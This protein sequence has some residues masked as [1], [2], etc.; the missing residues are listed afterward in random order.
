M[1][2]AS[3][4]S[5]ASDSYLSH[6]SQDS[7]FSLSYQ[8]YLSNSMSVSVSVSISYSMLTSVSISYIYL[9][10]QDLEQQRTIIQDI[11]LHMPGNIQRTI[12]HSVTFT[13]TATPS[14]VTGEL[15]WGPWKNDGVTGDQ[16]IFPQFIS[17]TIAGY[18]PTIPVVDQMIVTPNSA[19]YT[20]IDIYYD[21]ITI[22]ST[23]GSNIP[24]STS[25]I[26]SQSIS[27]SQSNSGTS[28]SNSISV[29]NSSNMNSTSSS[30]SQAVINNQNG[31]N[32]SGQGNENHQ[33]NGSIANDSKTTVLPQTGNDQ[34][35]SRLGTVAGALLGLLG[36][37]AASRRRKKD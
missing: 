34:Q 20:R 6:L 27:M 2:E 11:V 28:G 7:V 18:T 9:K 8:S 37:G 17:P 23:S 3:Q 13:R 12:T 19:P 21:P 1:S 30:V 5:A 22:P 32:I 24:G 25:N 35:T 31:Q 14:P 4:F 29:S 16:A 10:D 15:V 33:V 26:E 36:L